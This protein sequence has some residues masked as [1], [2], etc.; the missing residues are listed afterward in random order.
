MLLLVCCWM[1]GTRAGRPG[2]SDRRP[3]RR[4]GAPGRPL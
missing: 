1:D 3:G 4:H 2:G